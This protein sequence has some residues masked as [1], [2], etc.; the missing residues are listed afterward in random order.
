MKKSLSLLVITLL[1]L[2]LI[3]CDKVR[4]PYPK[5]VQSLDTTLYPGNWASYPWPTFSDG[6][7]TNRNVV[8]EDYT[9]HKCV[10]CPAAAT[11]AHKIDSINAGKV[12]VISVHTSPGGIGPFQETDA[13]YT[14]NFANETAVAYGNE[15]KTG[16][17]FAANPSGTINRITYGADMF[18]APGSWSNLVTQTLNANDLKVLLNVKSNYYASTKGLYVHALI[19]PKNQDPSK[20]KIVTQFIENEFIGKQKFPGGQHDDHYLF[21]NTLRGTLDGLPFGQAVSSN[22]KNEDG[23]YQFDYS[24]KIPDK[25]DPTNCHVV[26][27]IMDKETYEIYQAISV[28]IQ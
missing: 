24:Y 25:F 2:S 4:N 23:F 3:G 20:L 1:T 10:F 18:Q 11:E 9:G 7:S 5:G 15:F 12:F 22:Q 13:E 8:L 28:S 16:Y 17:G 26:V 27:Y 6:F 19:D 14:E 21:H